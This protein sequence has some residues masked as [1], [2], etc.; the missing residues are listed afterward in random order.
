M[1][2]ETWA[3][4]KVK[5]YQNIFYKDKWTYGWF[6]PATVKICWHWWKFKFWSHQDGSFPNGYIYALLDLENSLV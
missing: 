1:K 6:H 4:K 5:N 3:Y 2:F